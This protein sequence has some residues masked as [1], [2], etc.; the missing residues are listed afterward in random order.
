MTMQPERPLDQIRLVGIAATGYHGVFAH[1]RRDGQTFVADVV[2]H[3]DTRRAA[4][5]DDLAHTINYGE[6]AERVAA[7]LSG[8]PADLI[9]TVAER[10]AA[11]VLAYG[12]AVA[13]DVEVHK[14][15]APITV[16]F[17]DV[18]VAIHRDRTR[19]PAAEPWRPPIESVPVPASAPV[20]TVTAVF[21]QVPV[22]VPEG[23]GPAHAVSSAVAMAV[24][25]AP[26]EAIEGELVSDILDEEPAEPVDVVL[27]LG[28]NLGAAQQTLR[29]AV[30]DLARV[31][32]LTVVDVSPL[33]RSAA[34]GGPEQPDYLNAIVLARTT[35]SARDLVRATQAIEQQ[36]GRERLEHWGPRT[37]DIDL[38]V[39]GATLAVTDD[40]ELPHPRAHQRA[41][42]LE[43]WA[44]VAP[45]AVLP[46][47][48]GGPV[49]LLAATAPDRAGIRWLA[50]D[51]LTAPVLPEPAP[52]P[53][54]APAP[55]P[56]P[57]A[58]PAPD[59]ITASEPAA[60]SRPTHAAA[61]EVPTAPDGPAPLAWAPVRDTTD[62]APGSWPA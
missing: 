54:P 27:A 8:E 22:P 55:A 9:E 35:L 36:H 51:W 33:A 12:Q 42:V 38:V 32:G 49:A 18:V 1:E 31:R 52:V 15:Q 10:I 2:V 34:V 24:L 21:P 25:R 5:S 13:V 57:E 17:A 58:S 40:L 44:Q 39:Y 43:P 46:G 41:F 45:D 59:P 37:L 11:T 4:A 6:L 3:L 19:L 56:A 53:E 14:P 28:A 7:V 20:R 48:G 29:D 16:P 60:V 26:E 61:P 62:G 30:S 23:A 47:L 50:L